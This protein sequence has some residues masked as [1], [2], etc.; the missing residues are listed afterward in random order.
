MNESCEDFLARARFANDQDSAIARRDT[1]CELDE[2]HRCRST[3]NG[4]RLRAS[5]ARG[6]CLFVYLSFNHL[7][8]PRT[9]VPGELEIAKG[10]PGRVGV[11]K[12]EGSHNSGTNAP[13]ERQSS[14]GNSP[15]DR[16]SILRV[17]RHAEFAH[18]FHERRAA[19]VQEAGR[20]R[21]SAARALQCL[22]NQLTLDRQQMLTQVEAVFGQSHE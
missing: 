10:V 21:N 13:R 20:L 22:L 15:L 17:V 11:S 18:L 6:H 1:A 14:G 8:L 7:T 5:C 4:F 19:Q 16:R 3:R 9:E 12:R 2:T